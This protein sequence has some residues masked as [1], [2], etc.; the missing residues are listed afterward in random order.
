VPPENLHVTLLF[1]GSV[2][3]AMRDRL[4]GLTQETVWKPISAR[5]GELTA[6]G[7]SALALRLDVSNE[8]I[9]HLEDRLARASKAAPPGMPFEKI[10]EWART[11]SRPEDPLHQMALSIPEPDRIQKVR[12]QHQR[13]P[14]ELHLT[15]AR[16]KSRPPFELSEK[17]MPPID[18]LLDR[19]VLY[20]SHLGPEGSRYEV[21]A[22]A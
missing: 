2:D 21:T 14:L 6:F 15:V 5:T 1:F 4:A 12:R 3:E 20:E 13:R 11:W 16:T 10:E 18:L 8:Q 9:E 7:K 22:E 19:L 17:R